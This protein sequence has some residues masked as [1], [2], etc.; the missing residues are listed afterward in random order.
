MSKE[1][2]MAALKELRESV[3]DM[4]KISKRLARETK[5]GVRLSDYRAFQ[6][7]YLK[8]E[9]SRSVVKD[10]LMDWEDLLPEDR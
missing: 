8:L 5:R 4:V 6:D 10:K 2:I 3:T 9:Q 1:E 7:T